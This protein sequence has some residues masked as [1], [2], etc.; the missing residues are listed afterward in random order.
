[1]QDIAAVLDVP[2]IGVMPRPSDRRPVRALAGTPIR[3]RLL[4]PGPAGD[5]PR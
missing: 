5:K 2:V 1:V 3:Q 4:A